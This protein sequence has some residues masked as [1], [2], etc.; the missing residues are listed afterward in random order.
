MKLVHGPNQELL[1]AEHSE[2][3]I[4]LINDLKTDASKAVAVPQSEFKSGYPLL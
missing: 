2:L 3:L 1:V 4:F